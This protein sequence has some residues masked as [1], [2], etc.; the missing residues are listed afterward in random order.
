MNLNDPLN[1]PDDF[2]RPIYLFRKD[3]KGATEMFTFGLSPLKQKKGLE[4]NFSDEQ[5][6]SRKEWLNF[7]DKKRFC[8]WSYYPYV[9]TDGHR[10]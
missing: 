2:S 6:I 8:G 5:Q 1:M 7:C 3:K 10:F 9:G 4:L